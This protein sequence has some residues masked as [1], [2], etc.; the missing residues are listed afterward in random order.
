MKIPSRGLSSQEMLFCHDQ[1]TGSQL[2]FKD[3]EFTLCQQANCEQNHAHSSKASDALKA[4]NK[5]LQVGDLVFIKTEGSKNKPRE[6]YLIMDI[7]DKMGT[8]QKLLGSKF[9][10]IRYEVPLSHLFHAIR[11]SR[12][13][14]PTTSA[15]HGQYSSSSS[16]NSETPYAPSLCTTPSIDSSRSDDDNNPMDL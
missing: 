5:D 3:C 2:T 4:K 6:P 16:S 9:Q 7:V 15:S 13:A 1:V 11:P 12:D 8:L 10:S 14:N